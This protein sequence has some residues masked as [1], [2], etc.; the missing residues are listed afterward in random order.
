MKADGYITIESDRVA[1][2]CD[3]YLRAFEERVNNEVAKLRAEYM[4]PRWFRRSRTEEEFNSWL[5]KS[6]GCFEYSPLQKIEDHCGHFNA[7]R[8]LSIYDATE[9]QSSINLSSEFVQL[10]RPYLQEKL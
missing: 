6:P 10:I 2:A 4:R 1:R 8:V 9:F 7:D 5:R 3:A